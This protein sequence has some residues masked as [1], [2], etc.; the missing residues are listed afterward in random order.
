ML[1]L[2]FTLP[3]GAGPTVL[4]KIGLP[5]K[6]DTNGMR[7][8]VVR[9]LMQEK[10]A[11]VF[12]VDVKGPWHKYP[13][14]TGGAVSELAAQK[15]LSRIFELANARPE[16]FYFRCTRV[17]GLTDNDIATTRSYLPPTHELTIQKFVPPRRKPENAKPNHEERRPAGNVVN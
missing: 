16:M 5:V 6:M 9:D 17:P 14:L 3:G 13:A 2:M 10:L 11:D 1:L 15:N 4:Q 7:P 8:E 12:A